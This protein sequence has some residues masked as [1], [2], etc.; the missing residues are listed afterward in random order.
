MR[1]ELIQAFEAINDI[2]DV[3]AMILR[4]EGKHFSAG[5]D[6]SEFGSAESI[7][8]ARRIRWD[9]DPWGLLVDLRVPTVAAI[10]GT[11]L[12]SGLEMSLLCD[13]RLAAADSTLGLPETK[14]AMLPAAGGTQGLT[15]AIG[16][17]QAL[18]LIGLA[19]PLGAEEALARGLVHQVADD[20]DG[21][22][23]RWAHQLARLDP[24]V[25][26]AGRRALRAAGDLDLGR[27]LDYEK[28]LARALGPI[29]NRAGSG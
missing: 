5:A 27:G 28:A 21:A 8:E 24:E 18:P 1:D 19:T 14:L 13:L 22:A 11:A 3:R 26:R 7:F 20:V 10:G 15:R 23:R 6:L 9:R 4:A 25:V 17:A 2:P 29:T 16:P 12:G